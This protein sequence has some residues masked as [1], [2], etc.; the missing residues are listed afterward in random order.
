MKAQEL[1]VGAGS[2]IPEASDWWVA[3]RLPTLQKHQRSPMLTAKRIALPV[4]LMALAV[5]CAEQA[6]PDGLANTG[7]PSTSA[8][9]PN[10]KPTLADARRGFVT[11][12]G[13]PQ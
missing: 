9:A 8:S 5:G 13:E 7:A 11:K 2:P 1:R 12:L 6:A 4:S 3:L 10:A